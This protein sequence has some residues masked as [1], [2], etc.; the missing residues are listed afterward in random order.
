MKK[1]S[2]A[3]LPALSQKEE[4]TLKIF[5]TAATE[6]GE[7][8]TIT[9]EAFEDKR[10]SGEEAAEILFDTPSVFKAVKALVQNV[11]KWRRTEEESR[12][13]VSEAFAATF[14]ITNKEAEATIEALIDYGIQLENLLFKFTGKMKNLVAII[15][16][17]KKTPAT[18]TPAEG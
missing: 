8:T 10:L 9:V 2:N 6:V 4:E 3:V 5:V 17:D 7:F 15:R 12:K 13:K 16:G 14:S 11:K 18:D 1:Q